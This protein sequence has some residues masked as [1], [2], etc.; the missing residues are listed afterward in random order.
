MCIQLKQLTAQLQGL[1]KLIFALPLF[2][3]LWT[4]GHPRL[5]RPC[6]EIVQNPLQIN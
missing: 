6:L 4:S 3:I 1:G 2:Q 5:S